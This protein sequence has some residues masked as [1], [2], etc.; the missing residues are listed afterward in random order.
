MNTSVP[1][2]PPKLPLGETISLSY[3]WF[4]QRFP[5]VLRISWVWL[6]LGGALFGVT[7]WLQL[8]WMASILAGAP[9][10]VRLVHPATPPW[11]EFL[12]LLAYLVMAVGTAS[13]AVAWH[14]RIIL[15]EQPGLSGGNVVS[16]ALW[17]FIGIGI[18]LALMALIPAFIILF[19][20]AILVIP[21]A[22][23]FAA[24]LLLPFVVY[25][26]GLAVLLRFSMLLPARAVGN[27]TL[28]FRQ[29]WRCTRGNTWRLFWGVAACS[30][31]P[32]IVLHI[33]S[34]VIMTTIG[35]PE[36]ASFALP[37]APPVI[38]VTGLTISGVLLYACVLLITPLY[39]GFLSHAYRH[40]I[41]G[42]LDVSA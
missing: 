22:Q 35:K 27:S 32:T 25:I 38:P 19:P 7:N 18:L 23:T 20:I 3:S 2:A 34:I 41:R 31:P 29:A 4:F 6:V 28:S 8:S 9:N 30:A 24:L 33:I 12:G 36:P 11:S 17:R 14:R 37:G 40:F 26:I 1:P 21:K 13:I 39:I 5:D 15:D 10:G 16:G 42:G